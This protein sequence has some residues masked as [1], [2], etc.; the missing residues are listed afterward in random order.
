[1]T[2]VAIIDDEQDIREYHKGLLKQN[3][4]DLEIVGE[5]D[6]VEM[7]VKLIKESNPNLVLL[8]IELTDGTGFNLLQKV[9]PYDFAVIFITAH[10]DFAIKAIK[11]SA[12]DYILKPANEPEFCMA[13]ERALETFSK[14]HTQ[15]QLSNFMD[16]FEKRMQNRRI[17]L[18]TAESLNVVDVCDITYCQSDN[19]YTTIFMKD[20]SHILTSR[21]LKEYEE[22]LTEYGFFRPHHSFMVNLNFISKLEKSDGGYLVMKDKKQIPVSTRRKASLIQ[23]L[24]SM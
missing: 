11:F 7:G 17:V 9:K 8:D 19:S 20:G 6:S 16:V 23:I 13:I 22:L 2:T 4:P 15:E 12:L 5:A 1:M 18:K 21:G 10:N 3:F 14:P 24:E